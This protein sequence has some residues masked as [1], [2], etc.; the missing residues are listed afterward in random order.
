M[1]LLLA[2]LAATAWLF[3]ATA[4]VPVATAAPATC[5]GVWVVVDATAAGGTVST[6]CAAEHATG[7]EAL[8]AAGFTATRASAM[9]CQIDG[10][11]ER[12]KV[13]PSA[14]WSYWQATPDGDHYGDWVYAT[15]G[16]GGYQ[17]RGG[18]AEGWMFGDG[19]T[20]PAVLPGTLAVADSSAAP[21]TAA[22]PAQSPAPSAPA[23]GGTAG[24]PIGLLV[25]A[26]VAVLAGLGI[27]LA[28][29]RAR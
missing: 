15:L 14:Y 7:A 18:D 17:P 13:S 11:P 19:G 1:K 25:V 2:L 29:R 20:P 6:G 22:T 27:W 12:C 8:A 3:T 5:V 10:L 16:P 9:I 23:P 21:T 24:G 26:A 28:R 4:A